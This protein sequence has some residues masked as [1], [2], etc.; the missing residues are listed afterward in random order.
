MNRLQTTQQFFHFIH[1]HPYV[2]FLYG[3]STCA[4]CQALRHRLDKWHTEY[5]S[6]FTCYIPCGDFQELTS[7]HGIFTVPTIETYVDGKLFQRMSGYFSLDQM[8][9][10]FEEIVERC[11]END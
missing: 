5:P 4:P 11:E 7:Q 9:L 1:N 8:L 2:I 3:S 6:V 10:R